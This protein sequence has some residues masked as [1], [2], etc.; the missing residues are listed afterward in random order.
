TTKLDTVGASLSGQPF[1]TWAGPVDIAIGTDAR[2][3]KQITNFVDPLSLANALGTLNSS[4][5]NGSFN[6]KE[7][8]AEVNVPLLDIADA[9][10]LEVNG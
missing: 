7:A 6:V 4:A 2:W 5:T 3:E 8:F 1:S 9:I 10:K